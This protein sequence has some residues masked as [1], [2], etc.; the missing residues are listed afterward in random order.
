MCAFAVWETRAFVMV[1]VVC[2]MP[3]RECTGVVLKACW[4]CE[5]VHARALSGTPYFASRAI[6]SAEGVC[7]E[8]V[9]GGIEGCV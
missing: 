7:H 1:I 8:D 9:G 6:V 5:R 2:A 4:G 3:E